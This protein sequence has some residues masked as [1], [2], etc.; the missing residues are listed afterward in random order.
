MRLVSSSDDNKQYA[1]DKE[2][3]S[4]KFTLIDMGN[5]I[6]YRHRQWWQTPAEIWKTMEIDIESKDSEKSIHSEYLVDDNG[7]MLRALMTDSNGLRRVRSYYN[8]SSYNSKE[9][10][11]RLRGKGMVKVDGRWVQDSIILPGDNPLGLGESYDY[12]ETTGKFINVNGKEVP[13][14]ILSKF[15]L[16]DLLIASGKQ[17]SD[18]FVEIKEKNKNVPEEIDI[19]DEIS[20]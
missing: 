14:T 4:M 8:D 1:L 20:L 19:D 7:R 11:E 17:V 15:E 6:G 13:K 5:Y 10:E 3:Y 9:E 16:V 2:N 18:K 12:D